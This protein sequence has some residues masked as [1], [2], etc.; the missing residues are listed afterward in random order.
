VASHYP[1]FRRLPPDVSP[2]DFVI[3][4]PARAA[5]DGMDVV[6]PP[7]GAPELGAAIAVAENAGRGRS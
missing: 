4:I 6:P 3:E 5:L 7:A 2:A 1:D